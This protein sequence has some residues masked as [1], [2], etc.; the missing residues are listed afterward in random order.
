MLCATAEATAN[1]RMQLRSPRSNQ[2][3]NDLRAA[4][5]TEEQADVVEG[6][7]TYGS[8]A[9]HHKTKIRNTATT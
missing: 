4:E 1:G 5:D 8:Q 2:G 9:L 7:K 6:R 3:A